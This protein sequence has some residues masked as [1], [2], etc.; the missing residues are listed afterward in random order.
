MLG[1]VAICL[2]FI[3]K[4]DP[5]S[6]QISNSYLSFSQMHKMGNIDIIANFVFPHIYGFLPHLQLVMLVCVKL[7]MSAHKK[8]LFQGCKLH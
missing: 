2:V 8:I 4:W 7:D 1:F 5:L 3:I 6:E